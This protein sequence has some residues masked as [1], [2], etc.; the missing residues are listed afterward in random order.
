M[1]TQA[2]LFPEEMKGVKVRRPNGQFATK[3]Q[4]ATSEL[5][6]WKTLYLAAMQS[7]PRRTVAMWRLLRQKDEE[8][9]RL[10]K[11]LNKTA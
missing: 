7:E 4:A 6:K 8:I 9:I 5:Q 11:L 2:S 3:L 10:K 1:I